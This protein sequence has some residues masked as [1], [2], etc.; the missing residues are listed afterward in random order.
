VS[1]D[2]SIS[3]IIEALGE[4]G[5]DGAR[6]GQDREGRLCVVQGRARVGEHELGIRVELPLDFPLYMPVV[7][8]EDP[9]QLGDVAHLI[10]NGA[11][12]YHEG[13]GS[14]QSIWYPERVAA[15][16]VRLA[17]STLE[18]SLAGDNALSVF[19]EIEWWW[20][21]QREQVTAW[22]S[23]FEPGDKLQVL[24]RAGLY[25]RGE[26]DAFAALGLESERGLFIPFN[27]EDG[28][29]RFSPRSL[30][31]PGGLKR[32]LREHLD[33]DTFKRLQA[34]LRRGNDYRFAVLGVRRPSGD[35]A[36]IGVEF[37]GPIKPHPLRKSAMNDE[38][39]IEPALIY[40]VDRARM[41]ERGG[42]KLGLEYKT[43]AVVGCGAVGGYV[44]EAIARTGIGRLFLVD[45]DVLTPENAY[46]HTLGWSPSSQV[47]QQLAFKSILLSARIAECL[48]NLLNVVPITGA[49]H[50]A[51]ADQA[52]DLS[53]IDLMIVAVGEPTLSRKL[54][55]D[56]L[57]NGG[58]RAL[59]TWLEPLGVGGH[60]LLTATPGETGCYECLCV[61]EDGRELLSPATDFVAPNQ[62]VLSRVAG[63]G[64]SYTPF[65][66]LDARRTAEHAVRL[67]VRA[68]TG[69][70]PAARL[71]SWKGEGDAARAKGLT[72]TERFGWT[73]EQLDEG[74]HEFARSECGVCGSG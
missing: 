25:V 58:P 53:Q 18:R 69:N 47:L 70:E 13:E 56:L 71:R 31:R 54:N 34:R 5:L 48:P 19:E 51:I 42:A 52:L 16:S 17:L 41:V 2:V 6:R 1:A 44:A 24:Y 28:R 29:Y 72:L 63:C 64:T 39:T 12:C 65:S 59:Y 46:R 62:P 38:T 45:Y 68:L 14:V 7:Y 66:D 26:P 4:A 8:V 27:A 10:Q 22:V 50:A 67:A 35:Q 43:V 57:A 32:V 9:G 23:A 36:L 49:V 73:S 15:E 55:L 21:R 11:I 3:A 74:A 40:R 30:L 20:S 61:D 60:A 37:R 33:S